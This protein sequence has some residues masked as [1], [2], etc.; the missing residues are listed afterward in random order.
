[1]GEY[2]A[3]DFLHGNPMLIC[4]VPDEEH[5]SVLHGEPDGDPLHLQV[6]L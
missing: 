2:L 5:P 4:H 6:V 1:M 3:V